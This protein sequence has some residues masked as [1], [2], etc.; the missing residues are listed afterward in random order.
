LALSGRHHGCSTFLATYRHFDTDIDQGI[1][2]RQKAFT[3]HTKDV[4]NAVTNQLTDKK[5][6]TGA[7][8][9]RRRGLAHG[10]C[11]GDGAK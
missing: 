5:L 1:K 2:Y 3:R 11:S 9:A 4:F 10:F 6:T 7:W 8:G